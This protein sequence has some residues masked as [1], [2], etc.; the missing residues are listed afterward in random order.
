MERMTRLRVG[1][2]SSFFFTNIC[3]PFIIPRVRSCYSTHTPLL[4]TPATAPL[5]D[6][7]PNYLIFLLKTQCT[8]P[9]PGF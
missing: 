6:S 7:P 3:K 5:P 8:Y 2:F 4:T 1:F 9:V